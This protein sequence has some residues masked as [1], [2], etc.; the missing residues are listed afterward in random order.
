MSRN[1]VLRLIKEFVFSAYVWQST[2]DESPDIFL[3]D[4]DEN[5]NAKQKSKEQ[6][7]GHALKHL[8]S[9]S[10][11]N[12]LLNILSNGCFYTVHHADTW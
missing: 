10:E 12:Q 4:I 3:M 6:M 11:L 5:N 9:S 2:A 7:G 8:A 1:I